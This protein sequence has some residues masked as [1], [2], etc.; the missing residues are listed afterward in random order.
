MTPRQLLHNSHPHVTF[1][2]ARRRLTEAG[3]TVRNGPWNDDL[4]EYDL[5]YELGRVHVRR[6]MVDKNAVTRA[7]NLLAQRRGDGHEA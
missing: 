7:V 5:L 3:A 6:G 4:D 2:V 1:H